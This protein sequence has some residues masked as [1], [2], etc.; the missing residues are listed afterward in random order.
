MTQTMTLP[1]H[2]A[3]G[4]Q[5]AGLLPAFGVG[6]IAGMVGLL[7]WLLTGGR[8]PLQNLWATQARP[9]DMPF[10]LLPVSQYS[11]TTIFAL[12]LMGGV[13]A[14]LTVN[15]FARRRRFALWAAAA[16]LLL[17]HVVAV[18]QSFTVVGSGLN[19]TT[20]HD[21]RV[22]VYFAGMLG[23]TICAAL[24]AQVGLWVASRRSMGP[25]ALAIGLSAVPFASWIAP[26]LV[27]ASGASGIAMLSGGV[28]RWLPAAIV[29]VALG[30]C[31]VRPARRIA[32]WLTVL[33]ALWVTPALLTALQYG[34]GM[35]V[36]N[37][38]VKEMASAARQVF[39][40]ALATGVAPALFAIAIAIAVVTARAL[41]RGR[42][43][44]AAAPTKPLTIRTG[45][46]YN[47][48]HSHTG[49]GLFSGG[50]VMSSAEQDTDAAL[51]EALAKATDNELFVSFKKSGGI[52]GIHTEVT[53][54]DH[55]G[56]LT[57]EDAAELGG[58]LDEVD[59]FNVTGG[60]PGKP[61]TDGFVFSITAARGRRHRTIT[62]QSSVGNELLEK[63]APLIGWLEDRAPAQR[64]E[65]S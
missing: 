50:M 25:I 60:A 3:T 13:F 37:G 41:I 40:L 20:T 30:C 2:P 19:L 38:D 27:T 49:V 32:V 17:I 23:G 47:E 44:R 35:R 46:G 6:V 14:G 48:G 11:A 45:D 53:L 15:I 33:A 58:L 34:L 22:V 9:D 61:I 16:G 65:V 8:L 26:A 24:A 21:S 62:T 63:L 56:T 64:P 31:G 12:L 28:L 59:F 1:V 57:E 54:S 18:A 51:A 55:D 39:P 5:R 52:T 7:P 36:L 42:A 10:A 43:H 4:A 29:G